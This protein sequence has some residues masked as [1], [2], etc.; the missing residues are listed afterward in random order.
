MKCPRCNNT[1][2]SYFY[3]GSKGCY[4]RKCISFKR[5]LIEEEL[6]AP[7]YQIAAESESFD[8]GYAL[9]PKQKAV[10]E[11]C[12]KAVQE[13]DVV[14]HCVCGAGITEITVSSISHY[15]KRGLKVAYAIA[16][17]EVVLEL[18]ERFQNIFPSARVIA[19]CAGHSEPLTG[20]LIVCTTHQ[21]Y[22][23]PQ[24][25]DLLI[26]DEVDAFPFKGNEV[27]NNIALN[28]CKGHIIYSTATIDKK[29]KDLIKRR[30]H[31]VLSLWERPHH[32]PL[33]IPKVILLPYYLG[34]IWLIYHLNNNRGQYIVFTET[35]KECIYIYRLIRN[36]FKTT[37]VYSDLPERREHIEAFRSKR[38]KV[39]I[40]TT[41]LERGI[42]IKGVNVILM[43]KKGQ[44]FDKAAII[45][46]IGRVGRSMTMPYGKA[47]VLT[48]LINKDVSE[49]IKEMCYANK[50]SI[51]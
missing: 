29:T 25:F 48:P 28:A 16:R 26:L 12:E 33:V 30:P 34:I 1:D 50:M 31:K 38:F 9:T 22:R 14:L 4:C 23:Y 24:T 49:A 51:L 21:L 7:Q 32:R 2:I 27:L 39:I 18:S 42:T 20:D 8:L 13:T 46:M 3:F 36:F 45:Q 11:A 19:V 15:L 6:I 41:V 17:R 47:Y 37:Y 35:K 40:A 5:I 44:V 10:S 43:I